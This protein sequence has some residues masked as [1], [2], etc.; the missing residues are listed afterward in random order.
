M[1]RCLRDPTFSR[2]DT[3]AECD[4]QTHR[5]TTTANTALSIA[6]RGKKN[7]SS[8]TNYDSKQTRLLMR[9]HCCKVQIEMRRLFVSDLYGVPSLTNLQNNT[10]TNNDSPFCVCVV[11]LGP[12]QG[13][14]AA[15][16]VCYNT[17][18]FA[19][20]TATKRDQSCRQNQ[21]SLSLF[22]ALHRVRQSSR[23]HC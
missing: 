18:K 16:L 11:W 5:H 3:I 8:V 10:H 1:W 2:F 12:W 15:R 14:R 17:P 23:R 22:I 20:N 13:P 21:Q 4:R 19:R 7:P 9:A 6:S